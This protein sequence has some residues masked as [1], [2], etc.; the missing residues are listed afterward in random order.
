[1]KRANWLPVGI[2]AAFLATGCGEEPPTP[3][4]TDGPKEGLAR[5]RPG[6][7]KVIAPRTMKGISVPK[8]AMAPVAD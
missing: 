5:P 3:E 6:S 8:G 2:F 1:M 7:E 4:P